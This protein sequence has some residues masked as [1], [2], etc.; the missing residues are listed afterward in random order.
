[1]PLF[2]LP[3]LAMQVH[4]A[5][6]IPDTD[7]RPAAI[8]R[9]I[10]SLGHLIDGNSHFSN[11]LSRLSAAQC[12]AELVRLC[13]CSDKMIGD[14]F[15]VMDSRYPRGVLAEQF[16]YVTIAYNIFFL[17]RY[18]HP[19]ALTSDDFRS[20]HQAIVPPHPYDFH[21]LNKSYTFAYPW[22][23]LCRGWQLSP[24]GTEWNG[25]GFR[26]YR[27]L[28][29]QFRHLPRRR[30]SLHDQTLANNF[31]KKNPLVLK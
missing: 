14:S 22:R 9:F 11:S 30:I 15:A 4:S 3:L 24:F 21:S 17:L 28:F 8:V 6:E 26:D 25:G 13:G 18:D 1:M 7:F 16:F 20:Y 12:S 23:H 19:S 2:L 10:D 29:T 5:K 27:E 31:L